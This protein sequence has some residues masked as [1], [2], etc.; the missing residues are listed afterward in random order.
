MFMNMSC[1]TCPSSTA[2]ICSSLSMSNRAKASFRQWTSCM[3]IWRSRLRLE[4]WLVQDMLARETSLELP[5]GELRLYSW[6]C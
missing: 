3:V 5:T 6:Y 1:Y 2:V 4:L